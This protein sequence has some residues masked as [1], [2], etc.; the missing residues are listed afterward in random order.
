MR[1]LD[2]DFGK[3]PSNKDNK[4]DKRLG[5]G[6][7]FIFIGGL[8]IF[9]NMGIIPQAIKHNIFSW[10]M[11]LIIIGLFSV[12]GNRN[13]TAGLVL[14]SIGVF[15]ILPGVFGMGR[16]GLGKLWPAA[17]VAIGAYILIR[18]KNETREV[19]EN[20]METSTNAEDTIDDLNV[21]SG[22]NRIITSKNF[23][24]GR[25][26]AIFGGADYNFLN[27]ELAGNRAVIDVVTIF[28]GT[29]FVIPSD[30]DVTID[31]VPIFGGFADKRNTLKNFHINSDK[32][33]II[34]GLTLFGGGE[35]RNM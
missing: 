7:V 11:I 26:T 8:L 24:G 34:K 10:Q 5:V 28:G 4:Q 2:D 9:S 21:F 33:L 3:R 20:N 25:I 31:V 22:A 16:I 29:K 6:I 13:K 23:M 15:F 19:N 12:A 17:F 30:W 1:R 14:I 32:R 27:T 18:R 35:V